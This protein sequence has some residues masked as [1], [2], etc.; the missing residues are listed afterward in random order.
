MTGPRPTKEDIIQ[1]LATLV[2]RLTY[3]TRHDTRL[4]GLRAQALDY[5]YRHDLLGSP[6][7]EEDEPDTRTVAEGK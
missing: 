1:N 2:R 4:S 6:L 5:L 7:R 3:A